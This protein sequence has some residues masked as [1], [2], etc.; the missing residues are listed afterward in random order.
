MSK[1]TNEENE[2]PP[3]L[4]RSSRLQGS[5]KKTLSKGTKLINLDDEIPI[6]SPVNIYPTHS[7]QNSPIH[8]F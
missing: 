2:S 5:M 8:H 1:D 4:R 7:P 6:P 3:K